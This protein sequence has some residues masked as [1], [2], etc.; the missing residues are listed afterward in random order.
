M[1]RVARYIGHH[2][3][4]VI[5]DMKKPEWGLMVLG[6][7]ASSLADSKSTCDGFAH[8]LVEGNR[9]YFHTRSCAKLTLTSLG[10]SYI[11]LASV[12]AFRDET[13]AW[14]EE[15]YDPNSS[16]HYA[17]PESC[18]HVMWFIPAMTWPKRALITKC[19]EELI[20]HGCWGKVKKPSTMT[21]HP[22]SMANRSE[23]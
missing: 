17:S 14:C 3:K 21:V 22:P 12:H 13:I 7:V 20:D 5:L 11:K 4:M 6:E 8:G 1:V 23:F 16:Q 9:F 2:S 18:G 10:Y 19:N 15:H